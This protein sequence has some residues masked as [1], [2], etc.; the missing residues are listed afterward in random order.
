MPPFHGERMQAY[1]GF[2]YG[3]TGSAIRSIEQASP[4]P[5]PVPVGTAR[6]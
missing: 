4:T 5:E 6:A 3:G 1:R 2:A